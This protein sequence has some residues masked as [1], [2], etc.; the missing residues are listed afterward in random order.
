MPD[1]FAHWTAVYEK[2]AA[3]TASWYQTVPVRSLEYIR[4]AGVAKDAP[5]L[6]VGGGDSTLVDHLLKAGFRNLTVL[7]LAAEALARAQARLGAAAGQV[8]WIAGDVLEFAPRRKFALW[9]DRAVLHFL[10]EP[11][12]RAAYLAV[13]RAAL[14]PGGH[15]ILATFGPQGPPRCSGL[16]VQRYSAA[17]LSELLG[18][19]FELV[20]EDLEHHVTPRGVEQ[21]F[22][23]GLWTRRDV[24]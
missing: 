21:Q 12:E 16:E 5:I 11:S 17:E 19:S 20:R 14:A 2:T 9:H 3:G 6:D 8:H 24:V 10:L 23:Y 4:L 13:L 22:L 1:R 18:P 7:D 15:V